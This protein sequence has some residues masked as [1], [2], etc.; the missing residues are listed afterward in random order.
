VTEMKTKAEMNTAAGSTPVG[1]LLRD[2]IGHSYGEP[3][4]HYT[5]V[6]R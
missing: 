5:R 2:R 3:P 6:R 4:Y 1:E